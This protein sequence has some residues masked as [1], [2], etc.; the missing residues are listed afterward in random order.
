M[1]NHLI[2][3]QSLHIAFLQQEEQILNRRILPRCPTFLLQ[4]ELKGRERGK[5]QQKGLPLRFPL[6]WRRTT[7]PCAI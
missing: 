7:H 1:H 5:R 3:F 2:E 4:V 6:F